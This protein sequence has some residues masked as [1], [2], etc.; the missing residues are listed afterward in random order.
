MATIGEGVSVQRVLGLAPHVRLNT[1]T[2]EQ[3]PVPPAGVDTWANRAEDAT[4]TE[5]TVAHYIADVIGI[6]DGRLLRRHYLKNEDSLASVIATTAGIVTVGAAATLISAVFPTKAGVNDQA[7]YSAELWDRFNRDLEALAL[8]IDKLLKDE[9][10]P[11]TGGAGRG[12]R[13]RGTFREATI[14]DDLEW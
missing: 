11:N 3:V 1:A 5:A 14:T 4:V 8:M 6:V 12:G 13:I 7:S 2:P 9:T 10:D